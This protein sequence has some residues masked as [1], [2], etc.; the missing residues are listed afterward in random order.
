MALVYAI[1]NKETLLHICSSKKVSTDF[2]INK[3]KLN[4][5]H[6]KGLLLPMIVP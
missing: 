3:T 6:Y 4:A 1:I 2:I 5:A